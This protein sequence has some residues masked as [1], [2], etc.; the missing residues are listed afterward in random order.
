MNPDLDRVTRLKLEVQ[1]QEAEVAVATYRLDK[2]KADLKVVNAAL[3]E[4]EKPPKKK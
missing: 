2:S 1:K 4:A 3:K